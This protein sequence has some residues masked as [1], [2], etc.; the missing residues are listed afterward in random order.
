MLSTAAN[1]KRAVESRATPPFSPH[2]IGF[3]FSTAPAIE[4]A[5]RATG[6]GDGPHIE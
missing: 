5:C 4:P 2:K 6:V 1:P 3:L